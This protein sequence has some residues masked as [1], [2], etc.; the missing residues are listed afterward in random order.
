MIK[1]RWDCMNQIEKDD[2]IINEIE[3]EKIEDNLKGLKNFS[4]PKEWI[5]IKAKNIK[6]ALKKLKMIKNYKK[7]II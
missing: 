4:F 2:K 1:K 7:K 6:D 3:E 5:N